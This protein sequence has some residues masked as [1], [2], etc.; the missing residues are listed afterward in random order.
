K[1]EQRPIIKEVLKTFLKMGFGKKKDDQTAKKHTNNN[2]DPDSQVG[3]SIQLVTYDE[4]D[5][6]SF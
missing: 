1:P 3:D 5:V 4:L 2:S 6:S